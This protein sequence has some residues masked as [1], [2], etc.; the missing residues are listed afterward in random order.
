MAAKG[1]INLYSPVLGP[2]QSSMPG[3]PWWLLGVALVAVLFGASVTLRLIERWNLTQAI[4]A[5]RKERASIQ[6]NQQLLDDRLNLLTS[7]L[8]AQVSTASAALVEVI[9]KRLAWVELFQE[10]SVRVPDGVWLL[11][12][13]IEAMSQP[14]GGRE[15]T[16][17]TQR[18]TIRLTGFA[19]SHQSV[20]QLLSALEQSPKFTAVSLKFANRRMEG[21]GDQV[22]F[23]IQGQLA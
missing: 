21:G 8:S 3:K 20:S 15:R 2:A 5:K 17:P 4:E 14:K 18:R 22:N 12:V 7:G 11:H 23:E 16:R 1:R 9:N 10:M 19:R 13:E 6:G